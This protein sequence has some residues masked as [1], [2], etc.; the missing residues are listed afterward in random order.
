MD[1]LPLYLRFLRCCLNKEQPLP[2]DIKEMDWDGLF[3]FSRQQAVTA[4]IFSRMKDLSNDDISIPREVL[5]NWFAV[6]EQIKQRNILMNQRCVELTEMLRK[7]GFGSCILKGQGN[8][9]M[10]PD[11]YVRT[12]GDIDVWV[13]TGERLMFKGSGLRDIIIKYVKKQNPKAE[14]RYYHVEY[15][16]QGVPV[17]LHFMPG[18]MNNPIYNRRLQ[19]WYEKTSDI[20]CVMAELPEGVG[21]IP[22]P[23]VV[24]NIVFQLAHM[25]HHFFDEGIGLR[26]MIDYYYLLKAGNNNQV[27][28]SWLKVHGFPESLERTLKYLNLY[29]FAGAVMYIMKEVLGLEE[30]CLIVPVDER[31]GKTLL[32]EIMRGGNFGQSDVR[33]KKAEG[34]W[35]TGKKYFLKHW[36]NLHFVREYPAEALCEPIFR[37]WH[38]FWRLKFSY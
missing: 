24:F 12:P 16:W 17:E 26:Q 31:R 28:G 25:M 30:Q 2:K 27:H 4:V 29:K 38:F 33:W 22:V 8:T 21:K 1:S 7:D 6:S 14:V 20:G 19:K 23:T 11:P 37:T 10:Y 18:I 3:T 13:M 36:R 5:L 34:R 32:K 9:L 15:E 35:F